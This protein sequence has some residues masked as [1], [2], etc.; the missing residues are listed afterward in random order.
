MISDCC[1]EWAGWTETRLWDWV[2]ICERRPDYDICLQH[3]NKLCLK[4]WYYWTLTTRTPPP[5]VNAYST[6]EAGVIVLCSVI[7][8]SH[9]QLTT[10]WLAHSVWITGNVPAWIVLYSGCAQDLSDLL[11]H[12]RVPCTFSITNYCQASSM[13][14]S[15]LWLTCFSDFTIQKLQYSATQWCQSQL[16]SVSTF[17]GHSKMHY[18]SNALL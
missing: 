3:N 1:C 9:P 8:V 6:S 15:L 11:L 17:R 12:Q 7:L 4:I 5:P 10:Y 14:Q 18:W 16:L 2:V 13:L